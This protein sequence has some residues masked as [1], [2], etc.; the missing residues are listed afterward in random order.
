MVFGTDPAAG[1]ASPPAPGAVFWGSPKNFCFLH[2]GRWRCCASPSACLSAA[3]ISLLWDSCIPLLKGRSKEPQAT[4][5]RWVVH[6]SAPRPS[7]TDSRSPFSASPP[8]PVS[9]GLGPGEDELGVLDELGGPGFQ[10][11]ISPAGS[12]QAPGVSKAPG[13][14]RLMNVPALSLGQ[15]ADSS[16]HCTRS[17]RQRG[18]FPGGFLELLLKGRSSQRDERLSSP[19]QLFHQYLFFLSIYFYLPAQKRKMHKGG[20]CCFS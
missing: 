2:S 11:L 16:Q 9:A 20:E 15:G 7:L 14:C 6:R 3:L 12:S 5:M 4:Q 10:N 13:A 8:V 17:K 19:S 18:S 1:P